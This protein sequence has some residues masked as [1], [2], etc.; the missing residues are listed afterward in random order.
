MAALSIVLMLTLPA[1]ARAQGDATVAGVV[2]YRER[3]ALPP[4]A[5]LKLQLQDVSLADAPAMVLAEQTIEPMGKAPPYA[6]ELAYDASAIDER[7]SYAVRAEIRDGDQLLFT[8]TE[9]YA[10]ITQGNPSSGLT[11]VVRSIGASKPSA[12]LPGEMVNRDWSLT[13]LQRAPGDV[14]TTT[15]KGV[16]IR[17]GD[18]GRASG[19]G[20]CNRYSGPYSVAAEGGLSF[21][22]LIAT[23]IACTPDVASLESAYFGALGSVASYKLEGATLQLSFDNGRGLLS[24]SAPANKE[25]CFEQ[26]GHC[27]SGR[28]LEFWQS[29]GGLPVFG[30]PLSDQLSEN[31]STVQYFERQRFELH[32]ENDAPYDVLLGRLGD[33]ALKRQGVDWFT[34][35]KAGGP[36]KECLLFAETQHNVCDQ[37]GMPGFLTYWRTHGLEFNGRP[38]KSYNEAL[39]LFGLPLSEPRMETNADGSQVLTQW[40]ERARFEY[41]PNNPAAA[42]VLLGRLGAE[43]QPSP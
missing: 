5:I 26:T 14:V 37:N 29:N 1:G 42:R 18:D 6:F 11:I 9:R 15:N 16:S 32:P 31:G 8:T 25:T 10:V 39:A 23:R 12:S 35:A 43:T 24:Y 19:S 7:H 34:L 27:V 30:Y 3:I 36:Q 2:L 13:S 38:G 22:T 17:F 28:F 41:H 21:G 4:G 40:F 33:E 20:G